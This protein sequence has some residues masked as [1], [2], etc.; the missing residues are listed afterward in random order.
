MVILGILLMVLGVIAILCGLFLNE[1]TAELLGVDVSSVTIFLIG[2]A[3]GAAIL[4]GF[5]LT[6]WGTRR[7]LAHRQE[8]KELLKQQRLQEKNA[9]QQQSPP[10]S[11]GD[12]RTPPPTTT[13]G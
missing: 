7:G 10:P 9:P 13:S 1:G 8:R 5:G 11:A 12:D 4:W 2:V 6:K 3:T